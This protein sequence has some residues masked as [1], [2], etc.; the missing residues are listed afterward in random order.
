[1]RQISI[2]LAF[3]SQDIRA[4]ILLGS[5]QAMSVGIACNQRILLLAVQCQSGFMGCCKPTIPRCT[6]KYAAHAVVLQQNLH[7]LQAL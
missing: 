4:I 1:M 3:A 7:F 6:A 2:P 5:I